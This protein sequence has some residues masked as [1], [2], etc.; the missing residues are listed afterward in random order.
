MHESKRCLYCLALNFAEAHRQD[1]YRNREM[2]VDSPDSNLLDPDGINSPDSGFP[3]GKFTLK[4]FETVS[5][6]VP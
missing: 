3:C 5:F 2:G 4:N 1:L 6:F